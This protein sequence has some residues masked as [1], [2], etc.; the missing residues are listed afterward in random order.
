MLDYTLKTNKQK[1]KHTA[2]KRQRRNENPGHLT[3]ALRLPLSAAQPG[4]EG[5]RRTPGPGGRSLKASV[6]TE[7]EYDSCSGV[8]LLREIIIVHFIRLLSW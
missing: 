4:S 7:L 2:G 8:F 1:L 3:P 5:L 6:S